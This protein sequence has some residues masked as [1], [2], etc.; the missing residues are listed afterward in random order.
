MI[1]TLQQENR[2]S[3]PLDEIP[4]LVQNAVVAVE[5]AR[6]WSHEGVDPQAIARA[7][8]ANIDSGESSQGGSTI[9]Q[10]YVKT[11]LLTPAKSLSRKLEEASLAIAIERNYSKQ[12]ILELYLNTVYFGNGA[13]GIDAASRAYFG[14]GPADLDLAQI[15]LLAGVINAPS[16]FDPRAAP[17]KA[18]E[19]RNL[20]LRR[21]SEQGY[22]TA[23]PA[24]SWRPRCRSNWCHR[25][26]C[27]RPSPTRR[28]TSSTR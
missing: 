20:V 8:D 5:D 7:A 24:R 25:R 21:M 1:T 10:Q 14:V 3:L 9:T 28:R 19:R 11:A 23:R 12:L 26:P 27:P 18:V 16:R 13:Y 22:I 15:A 4:A 6:F 2:T 17:E